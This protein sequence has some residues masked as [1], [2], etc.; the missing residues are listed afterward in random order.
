MEFNMGLDII[1]ISKAVPIKC[2]GGEECDDTHYGF[3]PEPEKRREGLKPGC[4]II[5]KGGRW[6]HFRAGSYA[7]YGNWRR[8]L[9]VLALGVEPQ[10]IWEHPRRFRGKPF[11]ELIDFPDT[12]G[13]CIGPKSSKKL[14][15]EFVAFA[16]KARAY[17]ANTAP[18]CPPSKLTSNKATSRK[19]HAN[20]LGLTNAREFAQALGAVMPTPASDDLSWIQEVYDNFLAAF[21]LA[22][23]GGF[24]MFC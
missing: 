18:P 21:R 8:E 14:H 19:G 2:Q 13:P 11:V 10:E 12:V 5:G 16:R 15:S 6:M 22:S 7:G 20:Q 24:V 1:A 23:N 3:C 9:A 4:H 17:Y